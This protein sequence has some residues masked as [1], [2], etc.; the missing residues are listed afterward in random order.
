MH[1]DNKY[2][3]FTIPPPLA[4]CT[5]QT[6]ASSHLPSIPLHH[7]PPQPSHRSPQPL[8]MALPPRAHL[9][10]TPSRPRKTHQRRPHRPH[11]LPSPLSPLW[12]GYFF[13]ASACSACCNSSFLL[14]ISSLSFSACCLTRV[15]AVSLHCNS[16]IFASATLFASCSFCMLLQMK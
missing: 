16:S 11:H 4:F 7:V 13:L 1:L 5:S 8:H 15:S 14:M 10:P 2:R 3:H 12:H 9:P 6:S